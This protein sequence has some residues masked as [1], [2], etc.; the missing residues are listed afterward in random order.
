MVIFEKI[1]LEF[2]LCGNH[3][4]NREMKLK[5]YINGKEQTST[6]FILIHRPI[7][8]DTINFLVYSL[9]SKTFV[10]H[11]EALSIIYFPN[12]TF[13]QELKIDQLI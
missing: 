4:D 1:G 11:S 7:H 13:A 6:Q 12:D 8:L 2:S 9:L 5:R 10:K 3:F